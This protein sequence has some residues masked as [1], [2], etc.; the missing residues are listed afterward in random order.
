MLLIR[1]PECGDREETE[2][3]YGGQAHVAYPERPDELSDEQWAHYVFFRDN[4]RGP[5]A[6]RWVHAAGCR[7][8]FNVVRDTVT[9]EISAVYR[10]GEPRPVIT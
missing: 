6:E 4:P 3:S 5:F 8:W 2:F 10:L 9:N 7:R 1:C